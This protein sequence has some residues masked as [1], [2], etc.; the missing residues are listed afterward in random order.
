[1][2]Q[3]VALKTKQGVFLSEGNFLWWDRQ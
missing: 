1:M 3:E 2:K